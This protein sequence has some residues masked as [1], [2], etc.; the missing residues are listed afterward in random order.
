M[1]AFFQ[2]EATFHTAMIFCVFFYEL[3]KFSFYLKVYNLSWVNFC[4]VIL[5]IIRDINHGSTF[6]IQIVNWSIAICL[7]DFFPHWIMLML[8]SKI[9]CMCVSL[10]SR[11]FKLPL[12]FTYPPPH[13]CFCTSFPFLD[14]PLV[15]VL[16]FLQLMCSLTSNP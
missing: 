6:F 15:S 3:Y 16:Y 9:I 4:T 8:L 5:C 10:H 14:S 13:Y 12:L 2:S 1:F 11:C 7:K